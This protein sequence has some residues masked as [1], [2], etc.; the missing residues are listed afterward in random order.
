[1]SQ[2]NLLPEIVREKFK[3]PIGKA[4]PI[5]LIFLIIATFGVGFLLY[6]TKN[7][8]SKEIKGL[9]SQIQEQENIIAQEDIQELLNF[10]KRLDS[11]EE[12]LNKHFYWTQIFK[13]IERLT[14]PDVFFE[15]FSNSFEEIEQN[16]EKKEARQQVKVTLKGQTRNLNTLAK[17]IVFFERAPEIQNADFNLD[18]Q[19]G[20]KDGVINFEIILEFRFA[21][22]ISVP[23]SA[24]RGKSFDI[25][26]SRSFSLIGGIAQIRFASD[27]KQDDSFDGLWSQWFDWN[28]SDDSK[29]WDADNKIK[30]W[31]FNI[32]GEK[33][34]WAEIEDYSGLTSQYYKKIDVYDSESFDEYE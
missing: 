23:D 13:S 9:N 21:C 29:G 30:S 4:I 12:I 34:I 28:V 10:Q 6:R 14:L 2:L 26:A 18:F 33:E 17:Q 7:V 5:I 19:S 27:D 25:D 3:K 8:L 1:M 24:A 32:S 16:G 15:N 20:L 31:T 22:D 11:T